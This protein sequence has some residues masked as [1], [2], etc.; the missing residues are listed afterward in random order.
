MAKYTETSSRKSRSTRR[1]NAVYAAV[2]AQD[3]R[4]LSKEV[5]EALDRAVQDVV[6]TYEGLLIQV[7]KE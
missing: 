4:P 2:W 3:G 7:G 1:P 6:D 5:V